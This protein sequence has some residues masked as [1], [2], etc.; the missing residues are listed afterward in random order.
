M[1]KKKRKQKI[2][3]KKE[4]RT[5]GF[6]GQHY[7]NRPTQE[8]NPCGPAYRNPRADRWAMLVSRR[9]HRVSLRLGPI[10]QPLAV[11][12]ARVPS[13]GAHVAAS[14]G[15]LASRFPHAPFCLSD[16][17]CRLHVGPPGQL[18]HLLNRTR[19]RRC[20]RVDSAASSPAVAERP[21]RARPNARN[22]PRA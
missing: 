17:L 4:K 16:L 1:E 3:K 11:S 14:R 12:P 7:S 20:A 6:M 15:P 18:G 9:A 19:L 21:S 22:L 2:Y 8:T 10:G 13:L 5:K